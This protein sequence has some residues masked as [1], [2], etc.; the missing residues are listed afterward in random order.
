LTFIDGFLSEQAINEAQ[1]NPDDTAKEFFKD[2][3]KDEVKDKAAKGVASFAE[4][5][6]E[7]LVL[8]KLQQGYMV[9]NMGFLYSNTTTNGMPRKIRKEFIYT[10]EGLRM[11][12]YKGQNFGGVRNGVAFSTK[13]IDQI[14]ALSS[15]GVKAR[16]WNFLSK[17]G[18]YTN[19]FSAGSFVND[20][21]K[22]RRTLS[23]LPA[24]NPVLA[25]I[26][27]LGMIAETEWGKIE[28]AINE[29]RVKELELRK[30]QGIIFV[31]EFISNDQNRY[32]K[33]KSGIGDYLDNGEFA[34]HLQG[35]TRDAANKILSGE[36]K[37]MRQLYESFK[38]R[39]SSE[40]IILIKRI[41]H[42]YFPENAYLI[43]S[44]Y[45]VNK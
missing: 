30:R 44:F 21:G 39:R 1:K 4:K 14:K 6:K 11:Q 40:V 13:G 33:F 15:I 20:M 7:R 2:Y 18:N 8:T 16:G 26:S 23:S 25:Y 27:V 34:Y 41:G 28:D 36:L 31:D 5:A 37:N 17:V 22:E 32:G 38:D 42:R 12:V 43:E 19:I 29:D 3:L 9:D 35:I 45:I 10:N 24:I